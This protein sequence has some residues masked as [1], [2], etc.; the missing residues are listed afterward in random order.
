[1]D[2]GSEELKTMYYKHLDEYEKTQLRVF[3]LEEMQRTCPKWIGVYRQNKLKAAF[4]EIVAV[5]GDLTNSKIIDE[6]L[7]AVKEFGFAPTIGK[8][9]HAYKQE[10]LYHQRNAVRAAMD[11]DINGTT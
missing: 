3:F 2:D 10:S 11:K 1:M 8:M 9:L 4:G 6:W 5:L 7:D